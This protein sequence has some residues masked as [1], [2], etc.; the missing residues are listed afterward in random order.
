[1]VFQS[2]IGEV[3]SLG[4]AFCWTISA[5]FFEKAGH[6]VG[7]LSVNLIRIF[8]ALIFLGL[9]LVFTGNSFFPTDA[10]AQNWFWLGLSG[11]VGFFYWRLI[12]VSVLCSYRFAYFSVSNEPCPYADSRNW[13]VLF[14]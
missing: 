9:T 13:M 11:V 2:H 7:S 1:M 3:A 12:V 6:K 4:V 8:L 14:K 10:S 5:L